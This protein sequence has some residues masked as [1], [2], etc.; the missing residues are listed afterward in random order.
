MTLLIIG[1][2]VYYT[3]RL[4]ETYDIA[5]KTTQYQN[6]AGE[7]EGYIR[8]GTNGDCGT[9]GLKAGDVIEYVLFPFG[10]TEQ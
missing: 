9:P 8:D 1:D 6:P 4:K 7:K 2:S 10:F 3:L 5:Y